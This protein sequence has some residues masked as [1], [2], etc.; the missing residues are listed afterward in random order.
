MTGEIHPCRCRLSHHRH[1]ASRSARHRD[2]RIYQLRAE[3][4]IP[5]SGNR[6]SEKDH[7]QKATCRGRCSITFVMARPTG[8]S[9]VGC[10]AS[11]TFRSMRSVAASRP[12]RPHLARSVRARWPKARRFRLSRKPAR[13][14]ARNDGTAARRTRPRSRSL[15]HRPAADGNVIRP[16]GRIYRRRTPEAGSRR[17]PRAIATSG[18]S[19]CRAAR[20]TLS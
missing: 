19:R 11:T 8:T 1:E 3:S 20:A 17:L 4:M 7:A 5:K 12:M 9:S 14:R 18:T 16:L 15:S 6:F 2:A 13:P 10:K